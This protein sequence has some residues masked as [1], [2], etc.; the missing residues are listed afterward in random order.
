MSFSKLSALLPTHPV[1]IHMHIH[2]MYASVQ[3]III[4]SLI[5]QIFITCASLPYRTPTAINVHKV[6]YLFTVL[7][8]LYMPT[9]SV[10]YS[11]V[12]MYDVYVLI[13]SNC[14]LFISTFENI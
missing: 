1:I 12:I 4:N 10:M 13:F 6:I 7:L 3:R 2:V 9:Y 5:L 11:F 8:I 14:V